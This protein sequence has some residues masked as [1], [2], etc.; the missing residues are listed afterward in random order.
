M[1]WRLLRPS[2]ILPFLPTIISFCKS[3]FN[4]IY[5]FCRST[6]KNIL[7]HPY[8]FVVSLINYSYPWGLVKTLKN[9]SLI[10]IYY[11]TL[12]YFRLGQWYIYILNGTVM[13]LSGFE[14][15]VDS[16]IHDLCTAHI[17][18][19]HKLQDFHRGVSVITYITF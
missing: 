1:L 8:L 12:K 10:K 14:D 15:L 18:Y 13:L 17:L 5:L 16:I 11:L 9:E 3:I 7:N 6:W 2:I 4:N 19:L